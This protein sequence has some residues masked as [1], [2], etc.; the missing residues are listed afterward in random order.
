MLKFRE[1]FVINEGGAG[2]HMLHPFDLPEIR[3]GAQLADLF[4][5]TVGYFEKGNTAPIKID[6]AN[7]SVRLVSNESGQKEFAL[8]RGTAKAIEVPTTL[9]NLRGYFNKPGE[10]E[11]GFVKIG[12]QVLTIFNEAIPST[13]N[14]LKELGLYDNPLVFFNTEYVSGATNVIG[15]SNKFLAIHYPALAVKRQSKVGGRE[16]KSYESKKLPYSENV[17][18][19]YI[20]KVNVVAQKYGYTVIH[21]ELASLVKRPDLTKILN[22]PLTLAGRTQSLG[23]WLKGVT[24][25]KT[26]NV[27][28]LEG[29]TISAISQALYLEVIEDKKPLEEIVDPKYLPQAIDGI[30]TWHATRL[31]GKSLLNNMESGL[32]SVSKQEGIVIDSPEVGSTQFKITG[33]FFVRNRVSPFKKVPA[34]DATKEPVKEKV[35]V[36][37]YGRFNPP[38]IGHEALIEKLGAE[39]R[40]YNAELVAIFPTYSQDS[41]RNPLSFDE[42]VQVLKSFIP[43]NIK[44]LPGGNTI[45]GVL[46]FLSNQGYTHVIQLAGSDRIPE[47]EK[48]V[49][50][51]NGKPDKKGET[52]F[53][54]PKFGF[55]NAGQRDPDAEGVAGMSATKVREAAVNNDY[56]TFEAGTPNRIPAPLKKQMFNAIRAAL[57]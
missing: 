14:Q 38:T 18:N 24:I 26:K 29:K 15:Y 45:F 42:K 6:G 40:K 27:T 10:P 1:Y 52:L 11:H 43:I 44:V 54:I 33:D 17:L 48:I 25:P 50:T 22:L 56:K 32:G 49:N 37:T 12:E 55:V 2:G 35:A 19:S 31:L 46:K 30:V 5:R 16:L 53:T 34:K 47:Y 41:K 13:T 8:Y 9:N 21:Q 20:E 23:N 39:G 3:T 7:A 57:T 4:E 28:T 51:Y 36:F